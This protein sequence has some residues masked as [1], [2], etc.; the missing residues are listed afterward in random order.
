MCD[1]IFVSDFTF[2]TIKKVDK[3]TKF[4]SVVGYVFTRPRQP[5][6]LLLLIYLK[7]SF[8]TISSAFDQ[9]KAFKVLRNLSGSKQALGLRDPFDISKLA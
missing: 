7:L 2:F 1:H 8:K 9:F 6:L 3:F 5:P 4:G